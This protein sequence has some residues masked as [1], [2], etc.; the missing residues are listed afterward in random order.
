MFLPRSIQKDWLSQQDKWLWQKM[1]TVFLKARFLGIACG[2]SYCNNIS[3]LTQQKQP[4]YNEVLIL[5]QRQHSCLA[6]HRHACPETQIS[7][8]PVERRGIWLRP[9][10]CRGV[11][12]Q[13]AGLHGLR[14]Q[15]SRAQAGGSSLQA[16]QVLC[17]QRGAGKQLSWLER[18]IWFMRLW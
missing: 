18:G 2:W 8:A 16:E 9:W 11:A 6:G 14:H 15:L 5:H 7:P 10:G 4:W 13:Q 12:A 3:K 17:D 1:G